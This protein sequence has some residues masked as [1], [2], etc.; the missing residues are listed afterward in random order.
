[1][2]HL[3]ETAFRYSTRNRLHG[4]RRYRFPSTA[5]ECTGGGF[6]RINVLSYGRNSC[7]STFPP[8]DTK[9]TAV[10]GAEPTHLASLV[11]AA[12]AA[13]DVPMDRTNTI[14]CR[15]GCEFAASCA[16]R[17][18]RRVTIMAR[19]LLRVYADCAAFHGSARS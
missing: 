9:D 13:A 19:Y 17:E 2:V 16:D 10:F 12:L 3:A 8:S 15:R 6:P 1:M 7:R 11:G 5:I 18:T 4:Q 14:V